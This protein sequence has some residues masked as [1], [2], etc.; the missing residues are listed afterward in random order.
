[1]K[2]KDLKDVLDN[3]PPDNVVRI[4]CYFVRTTIGPRASVQLEEVRAGFDWD[5]GTSFIVPKDYTLVALKQDE[6]KD[7]IEFKN[8]KG[9]L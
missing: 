1:M 9:K 7:F 2:V 8:H 3:Q 4:P 5:Q 6:L